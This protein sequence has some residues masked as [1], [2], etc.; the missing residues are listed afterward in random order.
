MANK[1]TRPYQNSAHRDIFAAWEEYKSVFLV[2][3][4]GSGKTF[5]AVEIVKEFLFSGKRTIWIAHRAELIQQAFNTMYDHQIYAG[6]IMAGTKPNYALPVQVCSIQTIARRADL[7]PAD[8]IV[9][10]EAHHVS[11]KS[12]YDKIVALYPDALILMLS[13]TPYRLSGEGFAN[14]FP[15]RP[16]KMILAAP[17]D[18]LI[19]EGWLVPFEYYITSVPDLSEVAIT[20]MGEY[21][22]QGAL[23]AMEMAPIVESYFQWAKGKQGICFAI[24]VAH[25]KELCSKYTRAGIT[26]AHVDGTTDT[27]TRDQIFNDFRNGFIK[28][29]CNCGITTEGTD[30]PMCEFVQHAAPTNSLAQATQKSARASRAESGLVDLYHSAS[31]RKIAIASSSKPSGII[32]DNAGIAI[33]HMLPDHPHNWEYYFN[34]TGGKKRKKTEEQIEMLV[35]VCEDEQGRQVRSNKAKE[36]EGLKLI[37]VDKEQRRKIINLKALKEFDKL[38]AQAIQNKAVKKPGYNAF[39]KY[40]SYCTKSNT[41]IP[42]EAWDYI[43]QEMVTKP[44]AEFQRIVDTNE[45]YPGSLP[46]SLVIKAQKAAQAKGISHNFLLDKRKQYAKDNASQMAEY[47]VQKLNLTV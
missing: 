41:F 27:A 26:A 28:V 39:E 34:G 21:E 36:V 43:Q 33:Q 4:A 22:E 25:S 31:E 32:L 13:A 42:P 10:D 2:M 12:Q 47:I 1:A 24:N 5:T 20:S 29:L 19:K 45:K 46:E 15:L 3:A 8:L 40:M 7:P 16:T 35:F 23:K 11:P 30:L 44:K 38:Y 17:A 18:Y 9:I 37:R 14:V 6:I